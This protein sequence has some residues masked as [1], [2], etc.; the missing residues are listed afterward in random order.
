M[1]KHTQTI[2]RQIAYQLFER[3]WSFV[4]LALKGLKKS[5]FTF[6]AE[7]LLFRLVLYDLLCIGTIE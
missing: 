7:I 2:L 5:R 4:N 6:I 1:V 3:V